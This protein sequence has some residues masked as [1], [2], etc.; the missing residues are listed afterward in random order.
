MAKRDILR[1]GVIGSGL[2]GRTHLRGLSD[3][4]RRGLLPVSISGIASLDRTAGEALAAEHGC[5]FHADAASLIADTGTGVL[6]VATPTSTHLELARAAAEARKPLFL[7]KPLG[8]NLAEA[9]EIASI[10]KR[11]RLIHQ[12]GLILRFAPSYNVLKELLADPANG[13]FILCRFRDDQMLPAGGH[14]GS[15]WRT[16]VKTAGGG[17]LLEHSIHDVDVMRWFFGDSAVTGAEFLPSRHKGIEKLAA[18]N[19]RFKKGGRGQLAS[20]WHGNALRENERD[21]EIFFENRYFRFDGEY[22][23]PIRVE[24]PGGERRTLQKPE[25]EERYRKMIGW[26]APRHADFPPTA[27]HELY[28][29]LK[30]AIEGKPSE[31]PKADEGL[32]A[33]RLIEEAY[34]LGG[35]AR[36]RR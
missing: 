19:L 4:I 1:V 14:Y 3:I 13:E 29:F 10:L 31:G 18:L 24:G 28:V 34:A 6:I 7:E 32:A 30:A 23:G 12:I 8:R 9:R 35:R 36:A 20:V 27:G 16:D 17:A 15:D 11:R 25:I 33:H 26:G 21:I 2:M 22:S 5:A